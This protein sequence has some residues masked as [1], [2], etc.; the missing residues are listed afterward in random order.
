MGDFS[1][2]DLISD[3]PQSIIESILTQLPIRDAVR[4]SILSSKWRYKWTTLTQL[5]FDEE[6]VPRNER[7]LF[8]KSLV[9]FVTHVLFLHQGPIHKFQI[10]ASYLQSCPDIDQWILFLSRNDIKELGLEFGEGQWFRV[11]SCLYNCK[12]LTQLALVRC[13]L[14]PPINFNGFISLK[15]LNL[16]Q[17]L[18]P[19]DAIENIIC[20]CPCLESL[21]LSYFDSLSLNIHAPNLKCL[22]LEGEFKDIWLEDTP[23]LVEMSVAMYMT[24][25][26]AE[27][28]EQSSSCNFVKCLGG[29]P[30]LERL[31]GHI[32]FTKY[33]SIGNDL[34]RL[35]LTY[36]HLKTIELYEVSFE[37][38]KEMLV[39]L[40]LIT[41][42]PNLVELHVSCSNSPAATDDPDLDFW[43]KKRSSDCLFN[44]LKVVEMTDM[45]GGLQEMEFMKFL[46]GNSPV[47]EIMSIKPF[48]YDM[49]TQLNMLIELVF[50]EE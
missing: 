44:R 48:V 20:S 9:N 3:L 18:V 34:G 35:P 33:L 25:D 43:E 17:V 16:H 47:L 10:S 45:S 19:P 4:T 49:E 40:C 12:K 42:S 37:D 13:E 28:F 8:Q 21:S 41:S 23:L 5:V 1:G 6:C 39:V 2:A 27:H 24:D 50:T 11:P 7:T 36:N 32:D 26:I 46:L 30:Q 29:V 15:S 22:Y 38:M 31:S 14:D